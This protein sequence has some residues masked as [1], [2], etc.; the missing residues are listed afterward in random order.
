MIRIGVDESGTGAWAG[1]FVVCACAFVSTPP[2]GLKDSKKL[3]DAR[4]FELTAELVDPNVAILAIKNVEVQSIAILGQQKAWESAVLEVTLSV[5]SELTSRSSGT[6]VEVVIDGNGS[7]HL[8]DVLRKQGVRFRFE[9]KAD[10][11]YPEVSAASIVAK[12]ERN[13][14]MRNLAR[15]YP[16]YGWAKNAG[17]GT[18]DH[19]AAL[20][21]HGRTPQHRAIKRK[22]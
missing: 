2:K 15:L 22:P 12:T 18:P 1:P 3:S 7:K 5:L 19:D 14:H 16:Q 13:V 10:A 11:S 4:R 17:Y 20:R 6:T 8:A 21:L 9:A